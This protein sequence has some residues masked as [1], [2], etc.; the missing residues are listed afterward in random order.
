MLSKTRLQIPVEQQLSEF[1]NIR[2]LLEMLMSEHTP[3]KHQIKMKTSFG[4]EPPMNVFETDG[5]FVVVMDIAG[6]DQKDIA[7]F[8]DGSILRISGVRKDLTTQ[9]RKQF[10][11]LEIQV[12]PFQR[13]IGIPVPIEPSSLSNRY[14]NGLLE[15]RLKKKGDGP[16]RRRIDVK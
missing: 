1:D 4:W 11:A 13:L 6:M 14:A 15:I 2:E 9:G 12:G 10:H 7:V 5:E 16:T 3:A 8:T